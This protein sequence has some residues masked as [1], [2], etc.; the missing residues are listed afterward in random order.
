MGRQVGD[1]GVDGIRSCLPGR[2]AYFISL[3]GSNAV[4]EAAVHLVW[5]HEQL[6]TATC[7]STRLLPELAADI[8]SPGAHIASQTAN[9]RLAAP[10]MH[11]TNQRLSFLPNTNPRTISAKPSKAANTIIQKPMF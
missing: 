10:N 4:V 1:M 6:D 9:A 3:R 2:Q 8:V 7:P 11:S 5:E